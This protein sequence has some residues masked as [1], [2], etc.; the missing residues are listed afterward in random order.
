MSAPIR[1]FAQSP[2]GKLYIT[3]GFRKA[4]VWDGLYAS[5]EDAGIAAPTTSVMTATPSGVGRI[6]GKLYGYQ[7]FLDR[8]GQPSNAVPGNSSTQPLFVLGATG[9]IENVSSASPMEITTT[10]AHGLT[11]GDTVTIS[12]VGGL[13]SANGTFRITVTASDK[14]KLQASAG[15]TGTTTASAQGPISRI[16]AVTETV[17]LVTYNLLVFTTLDATTVTRGGKVSFYGCT[18]PGAPSANINFG[19]YSIVNSTTYTT[20]T[21]FTIQNVWG[22][23][24]VDT[25]GGMV[26]GYTP[27]KSTPNGTYTGGG[28]WLKGAAQI[29][30]SAVGSPDSRAVTRQILRTKNGDATTLWLDV[31]STNMAATSFS[32][33]NTDDDLSE[34]F[35]ITEL[36]GDDLML[37]RFGEPP[38]DKPYFAHHY[39]RFIGWGFPVWNQGKVAVTN[40][41]ATVTGQNTGWTSDMELEGRTLFVVGSSTPLTISS[42]NATTQTLTLE[43]AYSGTTSISSAYA[44]IPDSGERRTFYWSDNEWTSAWN[45]TNGLAVPEDP[46]A[47]EGSGIIVHDRVV[48]L[49]GENRIWRLTFQEE[50][51]KDG[52]QVFGPQ[53]GLINHR[54][55]VGVEDT[56]YLL[57]RQGIYQMEGGNI[58][59]ISTGIHDLFDQERPGKWKINWKWSKYFHAVHDQEHETIQWFVSLGGRYP[60]HAICYQYR[61]ERWWLDEYPFAVTSSAL[62]T[63]GTRRQVFLGCEGRRIYAAGYGSLDGATPNSGT[64]R[65]TVATSGLTW[66]TISGATFPSS[67]V[68]LPVHVVSGKGRGQRRRIVAVSGDKLTVDFPWLDTPDTTS[69]LQIAGIAATFKSGW[70]PWA[71]GDTE[72]NRRIDFVFEPCASEAVVDLRLYHD[73]SETPENSEYTR[74]TTDND[75]VATTKGNPNIQIDLT[76]ERG[77]VTIGIPGQCETRASGGKFIAIELQTVTNTDRQRYY[78][79]TIA[80]AST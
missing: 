23:T 17:G 64:L 58:T 80:G 67:F 75:G 69:I 24:G 61:T 1:Y 51:S 2:D 26:L 55:A 10:A 54:C 7:R 57:D 34:S 31:E 49:C 59:P 13:T 44:I 47:G 71:G 46:I 48:Y 65:G 40:G 50:P 41:S 66:A 37:N 4:Q 33:T 68:N 9:D 78:E 5:I 73:H 11:T 38:D 6:S 16:E 29:S 60:R 27:F 25:S 74:E 53:R 79:A 30:Y 12:D 62:G 22:A 72:V 42:F 52:A 43:T 35:P 21:T 8:H 28:V 18:L 20:G 56:R 70:Y 14:F 36:D 63:L 19:Q 3:D 32:S 45:A 76:N 77:N 39:G 15:S